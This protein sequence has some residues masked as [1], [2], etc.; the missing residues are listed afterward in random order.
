MRQDTTRPPWTLLTG[1]GTSYA[2]MQIWTIQRKSASLC[3][4]IVML[5]A[6]L[7][8]DAAPSTLQTV[9]LDAER[10]RFWLCCVA[11]A[12]RGNVSASRGARLAV[13][14]L[15]KNISRLYIH[16][17]TNCRRFRPAYN[18]HVG[19]CG[20]SP[21]CRFTVFVAAE[22][23]VPCQFHAA[24]AFECFPRQLVLLLLRE[25]FQAPIPF[26]WKL[27]ISCSVNG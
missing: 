21:I 3:L 6:G 1:T 26:C 5:S 14:H 15:H 19:L 11:P 17:F 9:N 20:T 13:P 22:A 8:D 18:H 23:R 16:R 10:L 24:A 25:D 4:M 12:D 27:I 2:M 7:L